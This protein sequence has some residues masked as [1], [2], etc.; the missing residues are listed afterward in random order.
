MTDQKIA[1]TLWTDVLLSFGFFLR[2]ENY[3]EA[4]LFC[5]LKKYA[6]NQPLFSAS[7]VSID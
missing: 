7:E 3:D 5:E 6:N 4:K 2:N 1:P